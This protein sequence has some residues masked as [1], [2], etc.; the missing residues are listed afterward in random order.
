M[1]ER[2]RHARTSTSIRVQISHPS[3]GTIIGSTNDISDGGAQVSV[4][5]SPMPP[6]GTV[7]DVLF[8]KVAGPINAEPVQMKVMH[9][10]RNILGLM[11][12]TNQ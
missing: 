5:S 7:V 8:K 2:R 10:H 6:V 4:D 11:F 1:E 12:I 3:I 9:S